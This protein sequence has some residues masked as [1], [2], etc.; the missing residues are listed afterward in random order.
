M[1]RIVTA[2]SSFFFLSQLISA[3]DTFSI[4]AVDTVTGEVGSAGAS[5]IDNVDCGGCGGVI[6]ISDVHPGR[7]VIHTQSYWNATNQNNAKMQMNLGSSPQQIITWLQANDAQGNPAI[8]QYGIVDFD[9]NGKPRTAAFTGANCLDY[10]N[11][12][13]GPNYSIQGNILLGQ[14]ILDSMESRFLKEPGDL[15]CKLMAALQGAKVI[16][17]DT[18]CT[19]SGNSSL[20]SFLIVAKPGDVA[21]NFYIALNV[22]QGPAGFEPIDSLQH[23]FNNIH[24]CLTAIEENN[25]SQPN[26]RV[27]PN[28]AHD[29]VFISVENFTGEYK[30][31]F[32]NAFGQK[33]LTGMAKS[34][35]QEVN[36]ASLENG[37]FF[38]SII[39]NGE[40]LF[41]GKLQKEK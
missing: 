21:P 14:Q 5:C 41:S 1:K 25:L 38:Y 3:Q 35:R 17:A 4:C 23:L 6:I 40:K 8:R 37:M 33:V 30:Y 13:T 18:R 32:Y 12:I 20:S 26:F 11:H 36:I 2:I 15:A 24:S 7:G 39:I 9:S 16:G 31:E 27:L 19:N 29:R 28:P 22:P 34:V 10:K